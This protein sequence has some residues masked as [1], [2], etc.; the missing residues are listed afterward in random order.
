MHSPGTFYAQIVRAKAEFRELILEQ[1][2]T[3]KNFCLQKLL[4]YLVSLVI[5]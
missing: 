4:S 2:H 1:L 3:L 5:V